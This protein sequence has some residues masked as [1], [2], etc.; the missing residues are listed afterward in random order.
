MIPFRSVST[1]VTCRRGEYNTVVAYGLVRLS[2][3][4]WDQSRLSTIWASL[5]TIL[6]R[7]YRGFDWSKRGL[8]DRQENVAIASKLRLYHHFFVVSLP[9]LAPRSTNY[10]EL[11]LSF[12][13]SQR[14]PCVSKFRALTLRCCPIT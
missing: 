4:E 7:R 14:V 10:K 9:L 12:G 5:M 11:C 6:D 8:F 1:S 2:N 13:P 3:S